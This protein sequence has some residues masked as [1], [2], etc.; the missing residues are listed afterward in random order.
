M[1]PIRNNGFMRLTLTVKEENSATDL[2]R[3]FH[4]V[5]PFAASVPLQA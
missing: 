4:D 1:K 2:E 3:S 5:L